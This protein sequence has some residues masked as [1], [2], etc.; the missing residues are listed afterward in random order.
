[1]P[2]THAAI[3][4]KVAIIV[5]PVGTLTPTYLA[6]AELAAATAELHGATVARAYSPSATPANV[7]A[8]VEGA[9]VVIYFGHGY[10]NPSPYGGLDTSRQNGW[11]L[12]GPAARGTHEDG[13][14]GYVEYLGEDW[15]VANAR[16]APGFV[17]I[18]SN[19][20]YAPGASEGGHAPATPWEAAMRVAYYSRP[21]F[22]LGGS[23]YYATDFDGGA[24]GL[25]GRLLADRTTSYG[26]AFAWD[27]SFVPGGLTS[28][29]HPFSPGQSLW[30]HRSIY[31]DGPPNY[32]YAFAG[33]PDLAPLQAWDAAVPTASLASPAANAT[34][35]T[36][37]TVLQVRFSEMVFGP[38][39]ESITLR[40]SEGESVA[41]DVTFDEPTLTATV[42]PRSPL[43]LSRSYV[44]S[45]GGA[46]TDVAGRALAPASWQFTTRIDAD[47]LGAA[48]SVN[49]EA[50]SHRLVRFAD[51]GTVTGERTLDVVERRWL[52]ADLRVRLPGQVGSWLRIDDATLGGW[53]VNESAV[54]HASGQTEDAVLEPGTR[55]T[56]PRTAHR[57]LGLAIPGPQPGD[58]V[59]PTDDVTV[60]VDRRH[61]TDG[62][63]FLRL[64]DTRWAGEWVEV[65]PTMAWTE[66][67]SQRVT[68]REPRP[69]EA[70]IL[71]EPGDHLAFR[72]DA[73]GRVLDRR[74]IT[75]APD[76]SLATRESLVVNGTRYA[77]IARGDLAGWT[78]AETDAVRV[79][80]VAPLS[81]ARE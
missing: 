55:V 45:A 62:R 46:V 12:Q 59:A 44:L 2:T 56:L 79:V 80:D 50:G 57:L 26:T 35:V 61:V 7:L 28:Q 3:P 18:Y 64:A 38:L 19:T 41:L 72:F 29:A 76:Q 77:V 21:V 81:T 17:M 43:A 15:I 30:L 39:A 75:E 63:T 22:A 9:N 52:L 23:A 37:D 73:A 10:G 70:A 13:L 8:A 40:D 48:L 74:A 71:L 42:Q 27:P 16:P 14:D 65:P 54:A 36:P 69:V 4:T 66:A 60:T 78:M 6:F 20:C 58:E 1:P 49:L 32:W 11:A 5:G 68:A 31:T 47:P 24:A 34:D 33:N 53:W 67:A 25:L 51:D